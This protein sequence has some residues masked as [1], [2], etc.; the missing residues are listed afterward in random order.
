MGGKV[1]WVEEGEE[2]SGEG[3]GGELC[4]KKTLELVKKNDEIKQSL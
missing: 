3:G 1:N 4:P 2:R